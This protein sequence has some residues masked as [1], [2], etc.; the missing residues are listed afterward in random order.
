MPRAFTIRDLKEAGYAGATK[1][2]EEI[3]SGRLT[4]TKVGRR[5]VILEEDLKTWLEGLPK[6]NSVQGDER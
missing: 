5:T 4:A 1:L 6:L 2:Y 3:K